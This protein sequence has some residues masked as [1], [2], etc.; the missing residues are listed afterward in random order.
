MLGAC[1][2]LMCVDF[3]A[4]TPQ[5]GTSCMYG[6]AKEDNARVLCVKAL[7]YLLLFL[8]AYIAVN[9]RASNKTLSPNLGWRFPTPA[10]SARGI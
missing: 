7:L 9:D 2:I 4:G 5:K 1:P 6:N 3:V 10:R 8:L